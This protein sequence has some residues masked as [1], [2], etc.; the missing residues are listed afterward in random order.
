MVALHLLRL[1]HHPRFLCRP[2]L[3]GP[4]PL[5][6]VRELF[7]AWDSPHMVILGHNRFLHRSISSTCIRCINKTLQT[8]GL[9]MLKS[10][11]TMTTRSAFGTLLHDLDIYHVTAF[12]LTY[13]F[14]QCVLATNFRDYLHRPP[15][16]TWVRLA[17]CCCNVSLLYTPK[18]SLACISHIP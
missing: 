10:E 8:W 5:F 17:C 16:C 7:L 15:C 2:F 6:L 3:T 9:S 14:P 4:N 12:H 18:S 1:L 13:I 11:S